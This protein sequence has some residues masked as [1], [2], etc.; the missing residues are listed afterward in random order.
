MLLIPAVHPNSATVRCNCTPSLTCSTGISVVHVHL[1]SAE[2]SRLPGA[3][4]EGLVLP[5]PR[6]GR[7]MRRSVVGIGEAARPIFTSASTLWSACGRPCRARWRSA[8]RRKA[9][10]SNRARLPLSTMPQ[11]R[12][13]SHTRRYSTGGRPRMSLL[14]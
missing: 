6:V 1:P 12:A 11:R 13:P 2:I 7:G 9:G 8:H 14:R 5:M 3:R 4:A 10:P